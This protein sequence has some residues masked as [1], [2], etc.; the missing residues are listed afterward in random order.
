MGAD[1]TPIPERG[2]QVEGGGGK[3]HLRLLEQHNLA[4]RKKETSTDP[5]GDKIDW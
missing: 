5:Q 4:E 2:S 3:A 1:L